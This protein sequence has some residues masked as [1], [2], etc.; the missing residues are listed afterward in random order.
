MQLILSGNTDMNVIR[1]VIYFVQKQYENSVRRVLFIDTRET[2]YQNESSLESERNDIV[3][4]Y[5]EEVT[6]ETSMTTRA[7]LHIDIPRL[8]SERLEVHES[9]DLIIDMT[10]GETYTSNILYATASLSKIRNLFFL[11]MNEDQW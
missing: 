11:Y 2:L 1:H 6:I 7:K 5:I 9:D 4:R 10:T 8:I 3:R